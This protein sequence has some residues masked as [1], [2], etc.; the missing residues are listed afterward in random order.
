MNKPR[1]GSQERCPTQHAPTRTS[2]CGCRSTEHETEHA[3]TGLRTCFVAPTDA[4]TRS[5]WSRLRNQPARSSMRARRGEGGSEG[6]SGRTPGKAG[7]RRAGR[8]WW[9]RTHG[10][11]AWGIDSDGT[12]RQQVLPYID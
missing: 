11:Q 2:T 12:R 7:V 4:H 1:S 5:S 10:R 6:G 3:A 8:G 9:V